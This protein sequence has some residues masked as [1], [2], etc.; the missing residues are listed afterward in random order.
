M[1][2]TTARSSSSNQNEESK[3][4]V[5]AEKSQTAQGVVVVNENAVA[6]CEE[7]D[8]VEGA[9]VQGAKRL[10]LKDCMC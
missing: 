7:V 2:E 1:M 9:G 10:S 8:A 6:E 5:S 3:E 4:P